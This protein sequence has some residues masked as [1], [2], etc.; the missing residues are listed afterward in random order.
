MSHLI[1]LWVSECDLWPVGSFFYTLPGDSTFPLFSRTKVI[2]RSN[3]GTF[4]SPATTSSGTP[5]PPIKKRDGTGTSWSYHIKELTFVRLDVT[6]V[7]IRLVKCYS[8]PRKHGKCY[9]QVT[10]PCTQQDVRNYKIARRILWSEVWNVTD[11][12]FVH[13]T[14]VT[15]KQSPIQENTTCQEPQHWS[16]PWIV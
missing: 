6:S 3:S 8:S 1:P 7:G 11:H 15:Y 4:T 10:C 13:V 16:W 5:L 2:L 9:K 14:V 12:Q